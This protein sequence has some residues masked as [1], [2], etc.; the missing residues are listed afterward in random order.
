MF[1]FGKKKETAAVGRGERRSKQRT[2]RKRTMRHAGPYKP[3]QRR[4]AVEAYLKSGLTQEDF[5]ATWGVS[6]KSLINWIKIYRATGPKGLDGSSLREDA[7]KRGRRGLPQAVKQE[8]TAVKQENPAFGT[9]SV[10]NFLWRFRGLKVSDGSVRKTLRQADIP[11]VAPRTTRRRRTRRKPKIQRF[12]RARAMQLWQTDIT[13]FVL[14]RHSQRVYLTVFLDDYSRYIVSWSLQLQQTKGF[15]METLLQG[16]QRFGKPEEVLTDQGRQ[17]FSWRGKSDFRKLLRKQGIG[18]VVARAH[19]P[20]TVGKCERFWETVGSEFWERI[21]PQDLSDA[22]ERLGHFIAYYNH[23]RPHQGLG[24]LVPADRFFGAA[25]EV[26]KAIEETISKNELRLA[27]GEAPRKPVFLIGQIGGTPVSLHGEKGKLVL[28]TPDGLSQRLDYEDFGH[29]T[30]DP[31]ATQTEGESEHDKVPEQNGIE[32][33]GSCRLDENRPETPSEREDGDAEPARLAGEGSVGN[34]DR[35]AADQ[36]ARGGSDDHGVLAGEDHQTGGGS[37]AQDAATSGLATLATSDIGDGSGA[38][39]PTQDTG[40]AGSE[41]QG[42]GDTQRSGERSGGTAEEDR[43]TRA[44]GGHAGAD[45][46]SSSRDAGLQRCEDTHGG[47][48]VRGA[49][50]SDRTGCS[51]NPEDQEND[52]SNTGRSSS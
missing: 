6:A 51:S 37:A 35:G 27:L 29:P 23:F 45:H 19:H 39:G 41:E 34:R 10:R 50:G 2:G 12:E 44:H 46:R 24:G 5:A 26:R 18:H 17:Y 30:K 22:Q 11:P 40:P 14:A 8:I 43:E 15:V 20:E 3:E 47:A 7:K 36:G 28:Q 21:E 52:E 13:S 38:S 32:S 48:S 4:Q 31:T 49:Q 42:R 1:S 16:I 33:D 9:R 25:N